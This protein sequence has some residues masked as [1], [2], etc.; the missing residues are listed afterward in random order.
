MDE[1]FLKAVDLPY[2]VR[3]ILRGCRSL[4]MPESREEIFSLAMGNQTAGAFEDAY[5]IEY[6][7]VLDVITCC[8]DNGSVEDYPKLMRTVEE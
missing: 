4:L 7:R 1:K 6:R 2:A 8:M 5:E 3:E